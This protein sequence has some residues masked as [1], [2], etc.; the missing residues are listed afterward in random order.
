MHKFSPAL[1]LTPSLPWQQFQGAMREQCCLSFTESKMIAI[2]KSCTHDSLPVQLNKHIPLVNLHIPLKRIIIQRII[3]RA[4]SC[5]E[6][7]L[8]IWLAFPKLMYEQGQLRAMT[9]LF[10]K[11]AVEAPVF[12]RQQEICLRLN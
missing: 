8:K 5:G 7:T 9:V 12:A 3:I 2:L 6:A 11:K 4:L 10:T 1:T